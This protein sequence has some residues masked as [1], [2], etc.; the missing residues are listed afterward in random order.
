MISAVLLPYRHDRYVGEII[1]STICNGA[2]PAK[3]MCRAGEG[4]VDSFCETLEALDDEDCDLDAAEC[5]A[6]LEACGCEDIDCEIGVERRKALSN[7]IAHGEALTMPALVL[8]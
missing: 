5:G 7:L 6:V 8:S 1:D 2:C 4:S 3:A